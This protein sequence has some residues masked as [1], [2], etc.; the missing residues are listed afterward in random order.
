MS[1]PDWE[2]NNK[3]YGMSARNNKINTIAST[4]SLARITHIMRT[5]SS[6]VIFT[7]VDDAPP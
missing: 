6:S 5:P 4:I 2:I 3:S 1:V 7:R